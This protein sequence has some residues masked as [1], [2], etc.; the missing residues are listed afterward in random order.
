MGSQ[1][2]PRRGSGRYRVLLDQLEDVADRLD[3]SERRMVRLENT[4][5]AVTARTSDL[6]VGTVCTHCEESFLLLER[7]RFRCPRCGHARTW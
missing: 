7:D 2:L 6:A 3:S 1:E 5:R 4:L